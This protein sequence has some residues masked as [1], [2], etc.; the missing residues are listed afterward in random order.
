MKLTFLSI[1][2]LKCRSLLVIGFTV[3]VVVWDITLGPF[4]SPFFT[5]PPP[6]ISRHQQTHRGDIF[7]IKWQF[8]ISLDLTLKWKNTAFWNTIT[9]PAS[10]P[11]P[12]QPAL[13]YPILL[14][15]SPIAQMSGHPTPQWCVQEKQGQHSRDGSFSQIATRVRS[16]PSAKLASQERLGPAMCWRKTG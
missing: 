15:L 11:Y 8:S 14:F 5:H 1:L 9:A 6:Q 3:F 16:S 2:P 12:A 4:S 10:N 7:L 13:H